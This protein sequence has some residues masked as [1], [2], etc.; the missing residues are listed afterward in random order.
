LAR[1]HFRRDKCKRAPRI[2]NANECNRIRKC[3][4]TLFGGDGHSTGA[5]GLIY[6]LRTVS[7]GACDCYKQKARLYLAAVGRHT[8]DLDPG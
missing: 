7:F 6:K 5:N 1:K 2:G 3:V 8:D 4:G